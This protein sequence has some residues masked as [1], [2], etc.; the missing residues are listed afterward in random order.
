M[1][2]R[3]LLYS[4]LLF[5]VASGSL[6]AQ[7]GWFPLKNSPKATWPAGY[8]SIY[9]VSADTGFICGGLGKPSRTTDGGATWVPIPVHGGRFKFFHNNR[10]GV[11]F[12]DG[13]TSFTTDCG[14]TWR[15]HPGLFCVDIDFPSDSVGYVVSMGNDS[16]RSIL[17]KST[18]R[19]QTWKYKYA[20][21]PVG[22]PSRVVGVQALAFSDDSRGFITE[23]TETWDGSGGGDLGFATTD[24]GE[25]W[26]GGGI[27]STQ[28]L[29]VTERTWLAVAS[30]DGTI[31]KTFDDWHTFHDAGVNVVN[32]QVRPGGSIAIC[33]SVNIVSFNHLGGS[34][35][36]STDGGDNWYYQFGGHTL[37]DWPGSVSLPTPLVGYVIGIDSQIYKT[38]DGG[39]PPFTA[40]VGSPFLSNVPVKL[41]PNPA[42]NYAELSF[43]T[44]A[45]S[46]RFELFNS[47]GRK[48][49][50]DE[51]PAGKRNYHFD[52]S[53]FPTG[54]Y[55]ARFQGRAYR[56]VKLS[57]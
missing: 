14:Y 51:V 12:A 44:L 53:R 40:S 28:M 19:G 23:V 20:L 33:D 55:I 2:F 41:S 52:I 47:I 29:H 43:S 48:L 32:S 39:G 34:I 15:E 56:F 1:S 57:E 35:C 16:T 42:H 5:G 45:S 9:F 38:T 22:T 4:C 10:L 8:L 49:L 37:I 11:N 36:R 24:G 7:S 54:V 3:S 31:Y 30:N 27:T 18:D 6:Y 26:K 50:I 25:S 17:G 46:A 13:T 21:P